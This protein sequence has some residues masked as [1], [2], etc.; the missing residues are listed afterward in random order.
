[1]SQSHTYR[2]KAFIRHILGVELALLGLCAALYWVVLPSVTGLKV[3]YPQ[4]YPLLLAGPLFSLAFLSYYLWKNRAL[5]RFSDL[6]L[7][8]HYMP[9]ISTGKTI[10][11]YYCLRLTLFFLALAAINP[12]LGSKLNEGKTEGMD[13]V[14][15]LD[16][17][18]S[19]L[20]EDVKPNRLERSKKLIS[21]VL[22][23]LH[24]DRIGIV[25]FAGQAFVQL[26]ITSDYSAAELFL[27]TVE[28]EFIATQGTAIGQALDL[29]Y[30]SFDEESAVSR[31]IVV[32][33]DG[34]NHEDDAVGT[35]E[36]IAEKGIKIYSIGMGRPQGGPIPIR[37][38]NVKDFKRKQD[39]EVVISKLNPALIRDIADAGNGKAFIADGRSN[40]VKSLKEE[41]NSL[42]KAELDQVMYSEYED[43]FQWFLFPAIL[44]LILEAITS[45]KRAR[46]RLWRVTN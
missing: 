22:N 39:G 2:R 26:P 44:L 36:Y 11:K 34:E 28:T 16:I 4:W 7:L 46:R 5:R 32:I 30:Q 12:Q 15:C 25:I 1:M 33:T 29:A 18:N 42:D 9:P 10:G 35:A 17:S 45:E 23:K 20:A 38:G 41:L 37:R 27:N 21:N 43:R 19:M 6:R 14:F 24:G 8:A 13:I 3:G 31:A 40:V